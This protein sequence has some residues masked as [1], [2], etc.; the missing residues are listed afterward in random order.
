MTSRTVIAQRI[1]VTGKVQGV[2]FRPFVYREA[3]RH[4]LTGWVRN[5]AAGVDIVVCGEPENL[6]GFFHSL[7]NERPTPSTVLQLSVSSHPEPVLEKDF[8]IK[9]S[10]IQGAKTAMIMPDLATCPDCLSEIRDPSNRRYLYPFT[11]C[12]SCGPRYSIMRGLPYDRSRTTMHAFHQCPDCRREFIDPFDRRFH[13]QPNACPTCGPNITLWDRNGRTVSEK[14]DAL[15]DAVLCLRSGGIVAVKGLGGFHLMA[16]AGNDHAVQL[17]RQRKHREEKPFAVMVPDIESA[18]SLAEISDVEQQW[19]CSPVAPIVLLRKKSPL[20]A[21]SGAIAPNN[22]CLG[23]FL[24]YTPLHHLLMD[25]LGIPLVATSGNISDEPICIDENDALNRL[26]GIADAFLVHNRPIAHPVDDSV[27]RIVCD[28]PLILRCARGLAP[29]AL[30]MN[31][32]SF[33]EPVLG[34]GPHMKA[35]ISLGCGNQIIVSPH[36]GD[37]ESVA[38]WESFEHHL[39]L[40]EEMYELKPDIV[41][42]DQHPHY[43]STRYAE[44]RVEKPVYV[45]HH[46]AHVLAVMAEYDLTGPV[47]GIVWDGTGFGQDGTIWGG[48]FLRVDGAGYKRVAHLRTFSLPGGDSAARDP[49]RSALGVLHE[50]GLAEYADFPKQHRDVLVKAIEQRINSMKTSSAGRLFDAT[51]SLLGLCRQSTYEGQAA[52]LL[53]AEAEK[54]PHDGTYYPHHLNAEVIDWEPVIRGLLADREAGVEKSVMAARF[55]QSMVNMMTA[56][57][58]QWPDVPVV[59][60][61]GC[62]QNAWLLEHAVNA[63]TAARRKVYWPNRL[64]PN[65]GAVSAGQVMYQRLNQSGGVV[66]PAID[67]G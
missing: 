31:D 48:E 30:S 59:L 53:Q 55:H 5:T 46:H 36:I 27:V 51:A 34:F 24:P 9:E 19:L 22:P 15:L 54:H 18:R 67:K 6:D 58:A 47:L 52:M 35:T 3:V 42:C 60:C 32:K 12:T 2:G 17:L 33:S 7:L 28:R 4:H 39:R 41:A 43:A 66:L 56:V 10:D 65:D 44:R 13:A 26:G 16:D 63:L 57:A 29:S 49:C 61:G 11:N 23:L 20:P 62:F 14:F 40:L 21:L 37:M 50:I 45:Q 38:A 64:P 1:L 8:Y 25:Q